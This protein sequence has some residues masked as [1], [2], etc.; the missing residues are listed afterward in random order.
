MLFADKGELQNA[1]GG[2]NVNDGLSAKVQ[3]E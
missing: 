2:L 1:E 3:G